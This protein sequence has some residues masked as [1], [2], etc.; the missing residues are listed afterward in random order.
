MKGK[1][2]IQCKRKPI[3]DHESVKGNRFGG[4]FFAARKALPLPQDRTFGTRPQGPRGVPL[5]GR[6]CMAKAY[7]A[8]EYDSCIRVYPQD[9]RIL[10]PNEQHQE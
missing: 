1:A 8:I 2:E 10:H 6:V 3:I 5:Q 7:L 4:S 9:V